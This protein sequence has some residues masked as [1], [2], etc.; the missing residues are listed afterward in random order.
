MEMDTMFETLTEFLRFNCPTGT[1]IGTITDS[2][3]TRIG[4]VEKIV[5]GFLI[6]RGKNRA[7]LGQTFTLKQAAWLTLRMGGMARPNYMDWQLQVR[8]MKKLGI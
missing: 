8:E 4:D 5:D 2:S 7:N 3:G 6:H 1:I